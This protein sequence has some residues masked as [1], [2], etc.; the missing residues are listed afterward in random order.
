MMVIP[1]SRRIRGPVCTPRDVSRQ[2]AE[3]SARVPR[4][5]ALARRAG[6]RLA[7]DRTRASRRSES[8]S[9]GRPASVRTGR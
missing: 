5:H 3:I 8:C 9:T 1:A 7:P 6:A 4:V 2:R